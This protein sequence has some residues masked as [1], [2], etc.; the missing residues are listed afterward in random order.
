MNKAL[1]LNCSPEITEGITRLLGKQVKLVDEPLKEGKT[2]KKYNFIVMEMNGDQK[3][4]V[5]HI[6]QARY[7]CKF[8]NLPIIL[9]T[10]EEKYPH[11]EPY[12][13]AGA[14]EI[15]SLNDPPAACRQ[16]L[17]SYLIPDRKPLE[18]EMDYLNPFISNTTE[19]L[20]K[21]ATI[22]ATFKDVYFADD[23]RIFGDIS[24][25]I[26]LSGEA[27]GTLIITFYWD[28]ACKVISNMMSVDEGNINAELIHDGVAELINMIAGT[29]KKQ[30]VGQPY[31]FNIS[32]PSVVIGSGHQIGHPPHSS[33]TVLIFDVDD[34]SFAVQLCIKPSNNKV[35]PSGEKP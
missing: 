3:K 4:V 15:L 23:F 7:V 8:R 13:S 25:I 30:F 34:F 18:K 5:E 14:T 20:E 26:G 19:I 28:L 17:Q 21:M 9:M 27:E 10:K 2:F 33:I 24:G 29:T 35:R 16:I 6:R 12:L 11:P 1:A 31:H 22:K 32:L